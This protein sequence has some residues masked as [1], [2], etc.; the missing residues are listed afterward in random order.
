[1]FSISVDCLPVVRNYEAAKRLHDSIPPI[2][3]RSPEIRPFGNRRD[4][5]KTITDRGDYVACCLYGYEVVKFFKDGRME[6]DTHG[7]PTLSTAAFIGR[8]AGPV[9]SSRKAHGGIC[10]QLGSPAP[11][12]APEPFRSYLL[13]DNH[14]ITIHPNGTV[15]AEPCVIHK[16]KQEEYK[17]KC[18]EY[19]AFMDYLVGVI[20][21]SGGSIAYSTDHIKTVCHADT[22][23]W[24]VPHTDDMDVWLA[25][26]ACI[27]SM[28]REKQRWWNPTAVIDAAKAKVVVRDLIKIN[29]QSLFER[30]TLP[31]GQV[32]SDPNRKFIRTPHD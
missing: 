1:M 20:K 30:V 22:G 28:L 6:L 5:G 13:T 8:V 2:R 16:L 4:H 21:V 32:K 14:S 11:T 10:V 12:T 7:Y 17:A 24:A 23:F 26:A 3:G 29:N 31:L 9:R 27:V 18:K 15:D 25:W 19:K